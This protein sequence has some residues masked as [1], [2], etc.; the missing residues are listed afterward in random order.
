MAHGREVLKTYPELAERM[1]QRGRGEGDITTFR[2]VEQQ[3]G[4]KAETVANWVKLTLAHP[5]EKA[6]LVWA[7][8]QSRA[9]S[10]EV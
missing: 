1:S 3:T 7:N 6:F 9:E 8:E 2:Q 10:T 5:E 4:R